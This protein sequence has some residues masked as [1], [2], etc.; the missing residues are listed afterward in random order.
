MAR[1]LSEFE[2]KETIYI[3]TAIFVCL[4]SSDDTL[5]EEC[6]LFMEDVEKS[7]IQ[8]I[9]ST[10]TLNETA[11]VLLK[12]KAG[13]LLGT[14][15]YYE[16]ITKLRKN[17]DLIRQSYEVVREFLDYIAHLEHLKALQILEIDRFTIDMAYQLAYKYGLLPRDA[18][19][20]AIMKNHSLKHIATTD[21]DFEKIDI[22]YVWKPNG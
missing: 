8:G 1:R 21:M 22:L 5:S 6:T 15:R 10:L 17:T 3:D 16:I 9:T 11:F 4:F 7:K 13:E 12:L 18:C 19:H 14:D 20:L 2:E